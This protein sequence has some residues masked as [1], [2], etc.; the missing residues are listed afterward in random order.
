VEFLGFASLEDTAAYFRFWPGDPV[1]V[2]SY[3]MFMFLNFAKFR[4][5]KSLLRPTE[6]PHPGRPFFGGAPTTEYSLDLTCC[7][8][9]PLRPPSVV[10]VEPKRKNLPE[11]THAPTI[12][13][14]DNIVRQ[15]HPSSLCRSNLSE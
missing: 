13:C 9:L 7:E 4:F 5:K 1:R 10:V 12:D 6:I 2:Q 11:I 15:Q 3:H 8:L 14:Q